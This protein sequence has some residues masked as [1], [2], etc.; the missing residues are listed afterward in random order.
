MDLRINVFGQRGEE[1][2]DAVVAD[3]IAAPGEFGGLDDFDVFGH[4]HEDGAK[5]AF[6]LGAVEFFNFFEVAFHRIRIRRGKVVGRIYW[7]IVH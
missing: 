6:L 7:V 3:V 1:F 5:I 2:F 4:Q